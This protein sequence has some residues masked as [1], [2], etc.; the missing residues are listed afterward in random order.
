[1]TPKLNLMSMEELSNAA[2]SQDGTKI[3]REFFRR[4][5]IKREQQL[6]FGKVKNISASFGTCRADYILS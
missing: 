5:L 4:A 1:M 6:L 2:A 3:E